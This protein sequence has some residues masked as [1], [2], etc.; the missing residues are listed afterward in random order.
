MSENKMADHGVL[1]FVDEW[2]YTTYSLLC[3]HI[4][5]S[6]FLRF[7]HVAIYIATFGI[8]IMFYIVIIYAQPILSKHL[9]FGRHFRVW[10]FLP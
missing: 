1:D 9:S 2:N 10:D 3:L 6:R 7:I 5:A 4:L 8:K